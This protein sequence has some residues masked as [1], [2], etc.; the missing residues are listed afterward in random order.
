MD[1]TK[2]TGIVLILVAITSAIFNQLAI[3]KK[4][5]LTEAQK[6]YHYLFFLSDAVIAILGT[7]IYMGYIL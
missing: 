2:I 1:I 3:Q 5:E 4:S 7:A 6:T